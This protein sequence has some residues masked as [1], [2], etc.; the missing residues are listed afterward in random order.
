MAAMVLKNEHE[1]K[2]EVAFRAYRQWA[3]ECPPSDAHLKP[4]FDAYAEGGMRPLV[5]LR[6]WVMN[7]KTAENH[8]AMARVVP[9]AAFFSTEAN[10]RISAS[11]ED[12]ALTHFS[13]LCLLSSI[14]VGASLAHA[15]EALE[16]LP[17]EKLLSKT[18]S[19]V[20]KAA[21]DW[22]A[23]YPEHSIATQ[24]AVEQ[25]FQDLDFAGRDDPEIYGP[26]IHIHATAGSA[27][28]TTRLAFWH[29]LHESSVEEALI[30]VINRGGASATHAAVTGALLGA[31]AGADA[32][33]EE[34]K[35]T[36][37]NAPPMVNP[38]GPPLKKYHP[39]QLLALFMEEET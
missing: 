17:P 25:V 34:W 10:K 39:R 27:R 24:A 6:H 31:L 26:D 1:Y 20:R 9:L 32:F 2:L 5:A 29:L 28:L 33:P 23:Q 19:E 36:V 18:K 13:P 14:C 22:S 38:K 8:A 30:D 11:L 35:D 16:P 4:L 12:C 7:R 37:W 21:V 3:E 15:I